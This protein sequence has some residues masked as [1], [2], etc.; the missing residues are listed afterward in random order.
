M[1]EF[2]EMEAA[3][4]QHEKEEAKADISEAQSVATKEGDKQIISGASDANAA[5][6]K[7]LDAQSYTGMTGVSGTGTEGGDEETGFAGTGAENQVAM[8]PSMDKVHEEAEADRAESNAKKAEANEKASEK[9]D[10]KKEQMK[11]NATSE[12]AQTESDSAK[13]ANASATLD[14]ESKGPDAEFLNQSINRIKEDAEAAAVE[15]KLNGE[16]KQVELASEMSQDKLMRNLVESTKDAL[17]ADQVLHKGPHNATVYSFKVPKSNCLSCKQHKKVMNMSRSAAKASELADAAGLTS[18]SVDHRMQVAKMQVELNARRA[19]TELDEA[20]ASQIKL[21]EKR[22][23]KSNDK[24]D[25]TL[26]LK[27]PAETN[28]G[29]A[30]GYEKENRTLAAKAKAE[31]V[32]ARGKYKEKLQAEEA[33]K[34][35][36]AKKERKWKEDIEAEKNNV[37][38]TREAVA[39]KQTDEQKKKSDM[40]KKRLDAL[41]FKNPYRIQLARA[42]V[43]AS[44]AKGIEEVA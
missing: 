31:F 44:I 9:A 35:R 13:A 6:R 10:A 15:R 27:V 23:N 36:L 32:K 7:I 20:V 16:V 30:D 41:T 14:E 5:L 34:A 21:L 17:K 24:A 19:Q 40:N 4:A 11:L 2:L 29:V 33:E 37:A 28:L 43:N 18:R 38:K 12:V 1:A 22:V 39:E 26:L 42:K 3:T 25:R 8:A